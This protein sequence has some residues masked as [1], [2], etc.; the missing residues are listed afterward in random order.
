[1][2]KISKY[3]LFFW[4]G[5]TLLVYA[6]VLVSPLFFEY[7]SIISF[8]IPVLI[9]ANVVLLI[10]SIAGRSKRWW[11]YT[12]LLLFSWP[13]LRT[14]VGFNDSSNSS[15]NA[16]KVLSYNVKW[17]LED[18]KNNYE[19]AIKWIADQDA[20]ILCFQ[21]FYPKKDISNRIMKQGGYYNAT[22]KNRYNVALYSKYPIVSKGLLFPDNAFNN[23]LYAD[24]RVGKRMLRVYSVHLQS[25]GI[26][27]EKIQD[28]EGIKAEY[29][30]VLL[31]ILK[32]SK[33][34]TRQ[35][36]QLLAH[37]DD[38]PYPVIIAGD[39]NDTPYSYNYFKV[40]S[41]FKNAF[42]E[43]GRGLGV[44]YNGKLPFLRIDNQFFSEEVAIVDF[45]TENKVYFSDH[46]ALVG[47]YRIID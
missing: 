7:G 28:S 44:T 34:R 41:Q 38:S 25:M 22:F 4:F 31:R 23:V 19:N 35:L 17:F 14:T 3:I 9:L 16:V 11:V 30:N 10:L 13:F 6:S 33:E 1:M 46:F 40:K 18:N 26:N 29:E 47:K 32:G 39:F 27:P 45:D 12:L 36:E 15:D 21:E 42:E 5:F 20:D 24:L 37:A 43:K 8:G 2:K